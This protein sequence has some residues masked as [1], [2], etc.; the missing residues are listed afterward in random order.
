M[1]EGRFDLVNEVDLV[2][3]EDALVQ[4]LPL[5]GQV[6]RCQYIIIYSD[7][8]S[9]EYFSYANTYINFQKALIIYLFSIDV[10]HFTIKKTWK[11]YRRN[12]SIAL[13]LC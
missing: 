10:K 1:T 7:I 11:I 13:H 9:I 8:F 5:S 2:K 6:C 4:K 12:F 3:L